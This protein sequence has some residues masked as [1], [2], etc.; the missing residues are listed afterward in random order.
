MPPTPLNFNAMRRTGTFS[1]TV[2]TSKAASDDLENIQTRHAEI[3][4]DLIAHRD[5]M[6]AKNLEKQAQRESQ[7]AMKADMEKEKMMATTQANKDAQDFHL[8]KSELDI[9]RAALAA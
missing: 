1:P 2:V 7:D 8:R 4:A 9:K 6:A 3:Q 5:L